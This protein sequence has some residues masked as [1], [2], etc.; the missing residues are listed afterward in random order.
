RRG[1]C[2]KLRGCCC[3]R[4]YSTGS[5]GNEFLEAFQLLFSRDT[6]FARRLRQAQAN[7]GK[8]ET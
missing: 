7:I 1:E 8:C 4:W 5:G 6:H 3:V 2:V